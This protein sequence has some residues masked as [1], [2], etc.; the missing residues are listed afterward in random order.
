MLYDK[1][2]IYVRSPL[3]VSFAGGGTDLPSYYNQGTPGH[4]VSATIDL[5]VYVS[6]KDMFDANVRVHHAE[7]ETEPIA[8]RIRH[9]YTRIALEELGL[10]KGVEV[11]LTS[12]VMTTG[13]GLGASS[14]ILSSLIKACSTFRGNEIS[15]K[16]KLAEATYELEQKAGNAGG[17]QDQY[18]TV[19]GGFNSITFQTEGVDVRP[20]KI[21]GDKLQAL[22]KNCFLVFTNLAR[23]SNQVQKKLENNLHDQRVNAYL[24]SLQHLSKQFLAELESDHCDFTILGKLL[25]EG[26]LLKKNINDSTS[27]PYIDQLYETLQHK[28]IVGGKILGAG[29]G[30]FFLAFARDESVK[31]R[32]KYELYPNFITSEIHFTKTGTE[33]LWKNF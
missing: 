30:G 4:V 31:Q 21:S 14:A 20:V 11:V 7:I 16:D 15:D 33:T 29:N 24:D 17:K 27:N 2:N 6:L 1:R 32:V 9:P 22:E 13:S 18:A 28:G 19:F 25:H 5:Y 26:W 23:H 8:S 10:F 3:R 12:D